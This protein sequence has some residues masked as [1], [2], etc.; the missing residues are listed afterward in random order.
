MDSIDKR[1]K[2]F[3]VKDGIVIGFIESSFELNNSDLIPVDDENEG[4][5]MRKD[6]L[7]AVE[8]GKVIEVKE[9]A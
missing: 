1:Y 2:Y 5:F 9:N 8:D 7:L 3:H 4:Y 6:I